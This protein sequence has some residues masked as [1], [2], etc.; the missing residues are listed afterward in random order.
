MRNHRESEDD[1][2]KKEKKKKETYLIV[3]FN[4]GLVMIFL[5]HISFENHQEF[6]LSFVKKFD[7]LISIPLVLKS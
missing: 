3:A 6:K 5:N 7:P 2:H 4:D 1:N